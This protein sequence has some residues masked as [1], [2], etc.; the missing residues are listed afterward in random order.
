MSLVTALFVI[1]IPLYKLT[2]NYTHAKKLLKV[3]LS[4]IP[5]KKA[6]SHIVIFIRLFFE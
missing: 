1:T 6:G 3:V 2:G 5:D 4:G